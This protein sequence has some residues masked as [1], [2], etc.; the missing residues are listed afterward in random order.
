VG[1][2]TA[3][4]KYRD[5]STFVTELMSSFSAVSTIICAILAGG[6]NDDDVCTAVVLSLPLQ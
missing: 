3:L 5:V 1:R 4:K 6:M 2:G